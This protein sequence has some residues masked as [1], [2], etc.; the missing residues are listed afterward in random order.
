MICVSICPEVFE[1]NLEDNKSQIV[2]KYRVSPEKINEGIVPED[3]KT[4][5]EQAASA[6]P[7]RI[8][9]VE[10]VEE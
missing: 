8:I 2:I 1:M 6:C 5:V 3:L 7:V 9:H 10:P 4:C